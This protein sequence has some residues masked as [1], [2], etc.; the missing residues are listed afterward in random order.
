MTQVRVA[1]LF[2]AV[3]A[4]ACQ[5]VGPVT[6]QSDGLGDT[7][8][9]INADSAIIEIQSDSIPDLSATGFTAI[10]DS[11]LHAMGLNTPGELEELAKQ[12]GYWWESESYGTV[13]RWWF[14]IGSGSGGLKWVQSGA[15]S[16]RA[17]YNPGKL[18]AKTSLY[19]DGTFRTSAEVKNGWWWQAK[20]VTLRDKWT[21]GETYYW[22][23]KTEHWYGGV[24]WI[25]HQA[26]IYW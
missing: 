11:E 6:V 3:L 5:T 26:S 14:T 2:A 24:T 12:Q 19:R 4:L 1:C 20:A 16:A 23:N 8:Y 13:E 25:Y 15:S 17:W 18:Y 21:T 10:T 9:F 22:T 7:Y